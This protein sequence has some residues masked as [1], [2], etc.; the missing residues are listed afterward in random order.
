MDVGLLVDAAS[1]FGIDA[2]VQVD[3]RSC[4]HRHRPIHKLGPMA[5]EVLLA[6]LSRAGV[7]IPRSVQ[8]NAP[9]RLALVISAGRPS[10]IEVEQYLRRPSGR[11]GSSTDPG[12]L[13][14]TPSSRGTAGSSA[15]GRI[16]LHRRGRPSGCVLHP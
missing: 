3:L 1:T 11:L 7:P 13:M 12:G 8:L 5:T 4:V 16:A 10:L 2:V 14:G 6:A 15:T 9:E